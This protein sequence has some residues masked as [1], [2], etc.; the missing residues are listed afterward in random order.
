MGAYAFLWQSQKRPAHTQLDS[1]GS[2]NKPMIAFGHGSEEKESEVQLSILCI[3][4]VCR[5]LY[6]ILQNKFKVRLIL[7]KPEACQSFISIPMHGQRSQT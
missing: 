7:R 6:F 3:S 5:D 4:S 1:F 2:T